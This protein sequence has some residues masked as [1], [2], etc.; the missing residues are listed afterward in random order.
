M[1]VKTQHSK[2]CGI[3]LKAVLR[4][5]LI[6]IQG[7]LK[8]Q[9]K[10]HISNVTLH[11][12][13]EENPKFVENEIINIRAEINEIETKKQQKRSM[14][15]KADSLKRFKKNDKPLARLMKKQREP[16]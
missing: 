4:G 8:K 6:A 13:K 11:L 2:I 1:K 9:E 12:E 15:L 7:Y 10:S 16:K 3:Q 5:M 14:E